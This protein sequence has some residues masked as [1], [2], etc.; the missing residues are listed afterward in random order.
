M[1]STSYSFLS[2]SPETIVDAMHN[3]DVAALA[4]ASVTAGGRV[5]QEPSTRTEWNSDR[6]AYKLPR[7]DPLRTRFTVF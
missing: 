3:Q 4:F 1:N 6:L 7:A 5:M 2:R